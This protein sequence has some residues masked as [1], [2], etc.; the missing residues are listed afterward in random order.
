L[1]DKGVPQEQAEAHAEATRE[2]VMADPTSKADLRSDLQAFSAQV[3][4]KLEILLLRL[5]VRWG[6]ML[7]VGFGALAAILKLP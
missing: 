5:T 1:R 3:D 7:L 6:I 2:F 4:A